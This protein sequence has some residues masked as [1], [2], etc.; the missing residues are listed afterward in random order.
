MY[1]SRF[2]VFKS[3]SCPIFIRFC[4]PSA[5]SKSQRLWREA[6]R[7]S[8][9]CSSLTKRMW[10]SLLHCSSSYR[11][12]S[13]RASISTMCS[14]CARYA[15]LSY[16][17]YFLWVFSKWSVLTR[18]ILWKLS[19]ASFALDFYSAL[20]LFSLRSFF[21]SFK[22]CRTRV[23]SWISN[24][25]LRIYS[26]LSTLSVSACASLRPVFALKLVTCYLL[27]LICVGSAV[28]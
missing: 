11:C 17:L 12:F 14:L 26:C 13:V 9:A 23:S 7:S 1:L 19:F 5:A 8:H 15:L 6:L 24:W 22:I 20:N 21:L 25:R 27:S 28:K 18:S 16:S 2:S 10:E 3:M 4:M